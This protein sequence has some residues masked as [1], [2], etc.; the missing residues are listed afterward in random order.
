MVAASRFVVFVGEYMIHMASQA[1][2]AVVAAMFKM[3]TE[4]SRVRHDVDRLGTARDTV[5]LRQRIGAANHRVTGMAHEIKERL[6]KL[7]PAVDT[8]QTAKLT[9]DFEVGLVTHFA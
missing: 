7:G 8:K 6:L 5:D 4:V 1:V 3:Q 9:S 2:K